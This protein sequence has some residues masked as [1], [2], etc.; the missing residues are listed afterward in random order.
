MEFGSHTSTENNSHSPQTTCDESVLLTL[1][2]EESCYIRLHGGRKYAVNEVYIRSSIRNIVE[3]VEGAVVVREWQLRFTST[4]QALKSALQVIFLSSGRGGVDTI[5]IPLRAVLLEIQNQ[6]YHEI[7]ESRASE[8]VRYGRTPLLLT[9]EILQQ[10]MQRC[11]SREM[12]ALLERFTTVSV[13]IAHNDMCYKVVRMLDSKESVRSTFRTS[14]I[15]FY[16]G[17]YYVG[18]F[19]MEG[20]CATS[21]LKFGA[22][23]PMLCEMVI[24]RDDG[25]LI[26]T[27]SSEDLLLVD[28][29][30]DILINQATSPR[31]LY[32]T[33][34]CCYQLLQRRNEGTFHQCD[35]VV[36]LHH[37]YKREYNTVFSTSDFYRRAEREMDAEM[38][39]HFP[40]PRTEILHCCPFEVVASCWAQ[41]RPATP[42]RN[43]RSTAP[44]QQVEVRNEDD[45]YGPRLLEISNSIQ[46]LRE[47]VRRITT[48]TPRNI[49]THSTESTCFAVPTEEGRSAE[50]EEE[51][52]ITAEIASIVP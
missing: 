1:I 26:S 35:T 43:V 22:E 24:P 9:T 27:Q 32:S 15:T 38:A 4:L 44:Q 25:V 13:D 51:P 7:L 23:T 6:E 52:S 40:H 30:P 12:Q 11:R 46:L 28:V 33:L 39:P 3:R 31:V 5:P 16:E 50:V 47:E 21:D 42:V 2:F 20:T 45:E 19:R 8:L 29:K 10:K 49:T 17:C 48:T 14:R 36:E 34:G 41:Q 37:K 18:L